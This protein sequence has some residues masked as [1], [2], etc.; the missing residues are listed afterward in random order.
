METWHGCRFGEG[1][2]IVWMDAY[3][4]STERLKIQLILLNQP[5]I[6][7]CGS[8]IEI[9]DADGILKTSLVL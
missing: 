2:F 3:D 4:I 5:E 7:I 9:I 8:D 1:E 6:L